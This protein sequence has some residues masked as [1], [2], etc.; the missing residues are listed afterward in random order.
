M[1]QDRPAGLIEA[2]AILIGVQLAWCTPPDS[3]VQAPSLKSDCVAVDTV[4]SDTY[5]G[6]TGREDA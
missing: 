5:D 4:P 6:G 2:E 3:D 1:R